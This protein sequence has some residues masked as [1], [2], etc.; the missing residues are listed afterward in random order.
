MPVPY[1]NRPSSQCGVA[2]CSSCTSRW[3]I[4]APTSSAVNHHWQAPFAARAA[5]LAHR[6][7]VLPQHRTWSQ[8]KYEEH[9]GKLNVALA[10]AGIAT[11]GEPVLARCNGP[12]TPW[13]VRRNEIWL[14]VR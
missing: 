13:F 8:S 6:R 9:V 7:Q 1:N 14:A 3:A 2:S 5:D 10:V 12:M 4:T 11:T